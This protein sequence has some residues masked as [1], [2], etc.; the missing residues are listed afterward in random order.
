MKEIR[1]EREEKELKQIVFIFQPSNSG[2]NA[3]KEAWTFVLIN[4][5]YLT[6]CF[7]VERLLLQKLET[8]NVL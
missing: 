2:T 3:R 8:T 6:V 5:T 1:E 7:G 4:L